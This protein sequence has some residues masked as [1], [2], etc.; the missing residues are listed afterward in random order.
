M[1]AIKWDTPIINIPPELEKLS[2]AGGGGAYLQMMDS[3]H[4]CQSDFWSMVRGP[5][6][7]V[8]SVVK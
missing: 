2:P 5:A 7:A 1:K 6:A 8:Q 3:R 4:L